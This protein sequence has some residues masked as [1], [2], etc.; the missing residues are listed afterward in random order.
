MVGTVCPHDTQSSIQ[1]PGAAVPAMLISESQLSTD[2]KT[3]RFPC[4]ELAALET[5]GPD[6]HCR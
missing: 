2:R 1:S 4:Q 6:L 5:I 3:V